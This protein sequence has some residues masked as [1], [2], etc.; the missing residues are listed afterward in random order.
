MGAGSGVS[1]LCKI[2]ANGFSLL[3]KIKSDGVSL[4]C[5][6]EADDASLETDTIAVGLGNG[7]TETV[8]EE[9]VGLVTPDGDTAAID[10][11][12]E[13]DEEGVT[14]ILFEI[15]IDGEGDGDAI[16][17]G[18]IVTEGKISSLVS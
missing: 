2:E 17:F 5:E 10:L 13:G 3:C 6:I 7:V 9:T 4:L 15:E 11:D 16:D 18:E 1:L 12:E 8:A 14:V